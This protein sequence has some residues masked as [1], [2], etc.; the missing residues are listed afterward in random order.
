[1][2]A[3]TARKRY[4]AM[5]MG[6]PWRGVLPLPDGTVA[7]GDRQTVL[8]LYAGELLAEVIV[9]SGKVLSFTRQPMRITMRR[10]QPIALMRRDD[11]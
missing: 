10:K 6:C 11:E 2:A 8:F 7:Q 5:H 4:S 9:I 3:D 1:M